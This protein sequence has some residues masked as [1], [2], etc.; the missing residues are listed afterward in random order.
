MKRQSQP[1]NLELS[2]IV[3][4][5]NVKDRLV[6]CLDS[7][8]KNFDPSYE[9]IVV[10]NNSSDG[11]VEAVKKG[12]YPGLQV[13][14][15]GSNLGF[16]GGNNFGVKKA[17]GKYV[18][19]LNPDTVVEQNSVQIA[20][21]YLKNNQDTGAVTVKVELP[22]GSLDYSCHRG[23]PTPW[24]AFCYFSGLT[25]IFP[26]TKLFSGYTL[27]YLDF[28]CEHEVDAITGA[29]FMLPRELGNMLAWFDT[30]FFWN[31]EDL[32]F[33]FRIKKLG[34]KIMYLPQA[35]IVHYKG[36]SGG[37]QRG[38]KT[39]NVRF[40]VMKLFFEKH[41]KNKYPSWFKSLVLFGI[42]GRKLLAYFDL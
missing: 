30:D 25:R 32:D 8:Y 21:D 20:L 24:N 26:K 36:S 41:Y 10:D 39:F 28:H 34:Y 3:L 37:H 33:C 18:L 9:V 14:E 12:K 17:R 22:D 11:S 2:V 16:A 35:K 29:Y 38:S 6:A 7:I 15:T 23:F 27:G 4:S 13:L 1:K 42:Q 19:F 31:G 5:Y 40:D